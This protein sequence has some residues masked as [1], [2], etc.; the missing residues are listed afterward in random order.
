MGEK[1]SIWIIRCSC[2]VYSHSELLYEDVFTVWE[3]IWAAKHISSE[4]F[5]LFIALALVEV[6]REIIRDNNMD[7]TDIIKFFN[8]KTYFKKDIAINSNYPQSAASPLLWQ[9]TCS[10]SVS[11]LSWEPL[12]LL[13]WESLTSSVTLLSM[14]TKECSDFHLLAE[15]LTCPT[16]SSAS[17]FLKTNWATKRTCIVV[18]QE[19]LST[20][21]SYF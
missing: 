11:L 3:V 17:V 21:W 8:G 7:F 18:C 14:C 19:I 4:H 2:N 16:N 1:W 15:D 5:V 12:L 20:F 6:Y 13:S 9:T 10:C